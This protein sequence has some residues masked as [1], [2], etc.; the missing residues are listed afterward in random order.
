MK[1]ALIIIGIVFVILIVL[2]ILGSKI[3]RE[4]YGEDC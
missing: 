2:C 3:A 1:T 4:F